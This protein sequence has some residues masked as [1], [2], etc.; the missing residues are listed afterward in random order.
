MRGA[1]PC[2][3]VSLTD[4]AAEADAEPGPGRSFFYE[5]NPPEGTWCWGP[6]YRWALRRRLAKRRGPWTPGPF[7]TTAQCGE[8]V[9]V[10]LHPGIWGGTEGWK[11][12][13][14][15]SLPCGLSSLVGGRVSSCL[16]FGF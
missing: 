6:A 14:Q 13:P 8:Q 12:V 15:G 3:S 1:C 2:R 16:G 4:G 9:W 10:A 11:L 5:Q 7:L